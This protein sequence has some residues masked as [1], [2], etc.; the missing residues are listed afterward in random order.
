MKGAG[1]Q[2]A[3]LWRGLQ[4]RGHAPVTLLLH[5]KHGRQLALRQFAA[6][7]DAD[8]RQQGL[9]HQRRRG[10]CT[11]QCRAL[12]IDLQ[13]LHVIQIGGQ[14]RVRLG[15]RMLH[16][17]PVQRPG[18]ARLPGQCRRQIGDRLPLGHTCAQ[19]IDPALL[20]WREHFQQ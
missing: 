13:H 7:G 19:R 20:L 2:Q 16:N 10:Q 11:A 9:L 1:E 18:P 4:C 12:A 8:L 17:R 15:K 3:W 6:M 14:Q 5:G